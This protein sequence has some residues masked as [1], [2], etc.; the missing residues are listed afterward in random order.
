MPVKIKEK[1]SAKLKKPLLITIF[2]CISAV[3]RTE[4]VKFLKVY[5]KCALSA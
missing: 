3:C 4:F 2:F 5:Q 1:G